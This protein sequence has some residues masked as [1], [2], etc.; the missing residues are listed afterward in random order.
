MKKILI[1]GGAGFIGSHLCDELITKGYDVT[2]YDNLLPQV[3][4]QT[5]RQKIRF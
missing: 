3:H 4:G 5:A 2:V 1:T